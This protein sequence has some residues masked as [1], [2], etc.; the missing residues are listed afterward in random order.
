MCG[1]VLYEA[2]LEALLPTCIDQHELCAN[3]HSCHFG[4]S[5]QE[6]SRVVASIAELK[7]FI[8]ESAF[9]MFP[10]KMGLSYW[11]ETQGIVHQGH[12]DGQDEVHVQ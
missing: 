8:A 12:V 4:M 3:N 10:Q 5:F 6:I 9:F 2:Y 7:F 11:V 1:G